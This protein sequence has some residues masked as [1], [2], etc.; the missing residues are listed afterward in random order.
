MTHRSDTKDDIRN[1]SDVARLV[2][3][4]YAK[5]RQDPELGPI[6]N[7]IVSDWE[8]HLDR[9]TDFWESQLFLKRNYVGNPLAVH[10]QVDRRLQQG[11]SPR[12]FGLW[13]NLWFETLDEL[14]EGEVAAI[15]KTRAQKM[16]TMFYLK[17]FESRPE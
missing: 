17:I 9:L 15:A 13:L 11:I 8:Q 6:F 16:S 3:R 12:H 7:Q 4:F 10:Q 2:K 5:V 1:R 14:F